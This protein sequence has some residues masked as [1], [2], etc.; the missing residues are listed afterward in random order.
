MTFTDIGR[1][2]VVLVVDDE[3]LL[4]LHAVD[5]VQG[6]GM[7]AVEA[8]NAEEAIRI[9]EHRPDICIVF[10]DLN[11]PGS[12]G[13]LKLAQVIRERWPPMELILTSGNTTPREGALPER[14]RFFPKPYRASEIMEAL[15]RFAA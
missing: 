13:G 11:M 8:S 9:L 3:P 14:G 7:A 6:A 2:I 12:M 4:R 15:H 1:C 5:V 10:T